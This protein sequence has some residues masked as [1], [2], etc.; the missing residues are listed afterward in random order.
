MSDLGVTL[1]LEA[2]KIDENSYRI[3][4]NGVRCFLF[5]GSERALL[6]DTGFGQAGGLKALV[7][8]LTDKPLTLVLTHSDPDH[9]GG[10]AEFDTAHM[11]PAEKPHYYRM[12]GH[13]A[14]TIDIN[15]GDVIDLGGRRFEVILK[16]GHTPGSIAFLDRENRVI[17]SGDIVSAGPVFMFGEGR[18]FKAYMESMEKLI[19][20]KSLFDDI[21]P[22]HGPLPLPTGQIDKMLDAAK[23]LL[24]GE[25]SPEE[26]PFPIP[27]KM[28]MHN[29]AGFFY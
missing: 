14:Q 10:L 28:Y 29:G 22:S 3:E 18:D 16:P 7:E 23:K 1:P 27:A 9:I 6:I 11:H 13:E 20:M 17:V 5:V 4:D 26:P 8:T 2:V 15:G 25:L 12:A 24:A 19:G 21:Y